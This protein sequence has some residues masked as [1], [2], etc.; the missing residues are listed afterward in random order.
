[1]FGI[2]ARAYGPRVRVDLYGQPGRPD[3]RRVNVGLAL[4]ALGQD[5]PWGRP[6][7]ETPLR[8]LFERG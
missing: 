6:H 3:R 4:L 5:V 8:A 2:D 1:M 7:D